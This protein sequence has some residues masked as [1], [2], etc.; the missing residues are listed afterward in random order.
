MQGT[1][2]EREKDTDEAMEKDY[3]VPEGIVFKSESIFMATGEEVPYTL[4]YSLCRE[5]QVTKTVMCFI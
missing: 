3:V 4:V 2:D 1:Q 5:N